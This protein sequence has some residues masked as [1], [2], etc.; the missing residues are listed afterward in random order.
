MILIV[1]SETCPSDQKKTQRHVRWNNTLKRYIYRI[2]R[3]VFTN[4]YV[5]SFKNGS[6]SLVTINMLNTDYV[7]YENIHTM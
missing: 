3:C 4:I 6:N 1:A 2:G 7:Q 5:L